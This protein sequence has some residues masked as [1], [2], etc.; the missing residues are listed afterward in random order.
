MAINSSAY[1]SSVFFFWLAV[2]WLVNA[3]VHDTRLNAARMPKP[4]TDDGIIS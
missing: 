4:I 2:G 1:V 3:L